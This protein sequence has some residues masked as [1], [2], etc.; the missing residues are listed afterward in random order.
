MTV[1]T[2]TGACLAIHVP[3]TF[4]SLTIPGVLDGQGISERRRPLGPEMLTLMALAAR[5][6]R[7]AVSSAR[8]RREQARVEAAG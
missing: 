8:E 4:R 2:P 3:A 7:A 5:L 6:L 1:A